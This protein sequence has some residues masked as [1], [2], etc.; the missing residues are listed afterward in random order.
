MGGR[1]E[2]LRRWPHRGCNAGSSRRSAA[3]HPKIARQIRA[4]DQ[5]AMYVREVVRHAGGSTGESTG[6]RA[7]TRGLSRGNGPT[8]TNLPRDS[9]QIGVIDRENSWFRGLCIVFRR[10]STAIIVVAASVNGGGSFDRSPS[11]R[12][13]PGFLALALIFLTLNPNG[14]AHS[15]AVP[16]L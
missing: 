10:Y 15:S 13:S 6:G 2:Y 16:F 3:P 5:R 1:W 7:C 12:P 4:W 9:H 11:P 8:C 14:S